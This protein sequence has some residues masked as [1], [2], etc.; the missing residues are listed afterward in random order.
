MRETPKCDFARKRTHPDTA[1]VKN[2]RFAPLFF[3]HPVHPFVHPACHA[4][5]SAI[6]LATA[7]ACWEKADLPL[8]P[9]PA[10]VSRGAP[11]QTAPLKFSAGP[12]VLPYANLRISLCRMRTGQRNPPPVIRL[13][14]HEVPALRFNQASQEVLHL[15][16]V[17]C[18]QTV[19]QRKIWWQPR[20]R[21]RLQLPLKS[22]SMPVR[23]L[24]SR[25]S[26]NA[27]AASHHP[28][29]RSNSFCCLDRQ[30]G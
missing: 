4:I 1:P 6:A 8:P 10:A 2:N 9:F 24:P 22:A 19:L 11:P 18:R 14:R 29:G 5:P 3:V 30:L 25:G 16:R 13:E 28:A 26:A 20:L 17:R 15:C 21:R 27:S 12:I 23:L 7:E